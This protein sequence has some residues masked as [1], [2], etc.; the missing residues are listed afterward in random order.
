MIEK[1]LPIFKPISIMLVSCDQNPN[2]CLFR[3]ETQKKMVKKI[4]CW[5]P[6]SPKPDQAVVDNSYR[7][8]VTEPM[9]IDNT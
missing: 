3:H 7:M 9:R 4:Y 5:H 1:Q 2:D 6:R 8:C